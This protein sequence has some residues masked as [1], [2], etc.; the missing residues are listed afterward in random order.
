MS[1]QPVPAAIE[2]VLTHLSRI[3]PERVD[4]KRVLR[5]SL[6]VLRLGPVLPLAVSDEA[7]NPVAVPD[8]GDW[9]WMLLDDMRRELGGEVTPVLAPRGQILLELNRV[10]DMAS[11]SAEEMLEDLGSEGELSREIEE[12]KDL[13]ESEDE[14]PVIRLVNTLISQALK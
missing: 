1:E 2:P 10:F 4:T 5:F 7:V 14:A 12:V 11:A 3:P 8:D 9:P 13:L 6:P